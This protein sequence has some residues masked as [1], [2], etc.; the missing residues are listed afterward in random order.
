MQ[1][2]LKLLSVSLNVKDRE[3]VFKALCNAPGGVDV[4]RWVH[5]AFEKGT[6]IMFALEKLIHSCN[7]LPVAATSATLVERLGGVEKFSI[8]ESAK[9]KKA[10]QK[11]KAPPKSTTTT[12]KPPVNSTST[13]TKPVSTP[14]KPAAHTTA[15]PPITNQPSEQMTPEKM[16]EMSQ[17]WQFF[18]LWKRTGG[19]LP[20]QERLQQQQLQTATQTTS[21][22]MYNVQYLI[23]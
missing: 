20:Q 13:P 3:E 11:K 2:A 4:L 5:T 21:K 17:M 15:V 19:Q 9:S 23:C 8:F 16:Q 6:C 14:N 7:N 12:N 18:D 22:G 1:T 10:A